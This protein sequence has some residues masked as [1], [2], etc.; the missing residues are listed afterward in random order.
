MGKATKLQRG[1]AP[2]EPRVSSL[3]TARSQ[4]KKVLLHRGLRMSLLT[5][6]RVGRMP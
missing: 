1:C 6:P 2:V 5:T 3:D 4:F